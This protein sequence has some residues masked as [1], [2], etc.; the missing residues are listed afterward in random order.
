MSMPERSAIGIV[1]AMEQEV[2]ILRDRYF[3]AAPSREGLCPIYRSSINGTPVVLAHSGIGKVNATI[4]AS[5][6]VLRY[7][8]SAL[9]V[10]GL[11]GSL[12]EALTAGDM[13]VATAA[14]HHDFDLTPLLPRRGQLPGLHAAE[15]PASPRLIVAASEAAAKVAE[16]ASKRRGG[17]AGPKWLRGAVA[18]GDALISSLARKQEITAHFPDALC[19]DME[20]AAVAQVAA[21]AGCD[22]AAVRV[23]SDNA[24]ESFDAGEVLSYLNEEGA[25]SIS[26]L[27]AGLCGL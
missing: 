4:A 13:V 2:S 25:E 22:W 16:E 9:L 1:V 19:V 17:L 27:L 12:G 6:L 18:S 3:G 20:T 23:V 26:A 24:D 11:A 5:E 14:V 8:P 10:S 7:R 15:L 21:A